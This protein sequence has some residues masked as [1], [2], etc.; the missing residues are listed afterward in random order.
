MDLEGS[1]SNLVSDRGVGV[2]R[3]GIFRFGGWVNE[4][5]SE[6]NNSVCLENGGTCFWNL[7]GGN[8]IFP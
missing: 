1:F 8:I 7:S 4:K 3:L 5:K 2:R 6:A